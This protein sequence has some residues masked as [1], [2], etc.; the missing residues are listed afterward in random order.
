MEKNMLNKPSIQE[1]CKDEIKDFILELVK[2]ELQNVPADLHCRRRDL[3]EAILLYNKQTG[4]RET[5]KQNVL[6]ILKTWDRRPDQIKD[7]TSMGFTV[8][9]GKTHYKLRWNNSSYFATLASSP[10]DHRANYNKV[11]DATKTFF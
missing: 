8:I 6:G 11:S 2:R 5:I 9:K 1:L 4:E 7:L 3:C 10:S